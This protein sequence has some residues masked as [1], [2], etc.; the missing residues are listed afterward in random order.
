MLKFFRKRCRVAKMDRGLYPFELQHNLCFDSMFM[1]S[2]V[3]VFE[4]E[5]EAIDAMES[6]VSKKRVAKITVI[7]ECIL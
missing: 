5:V 4:T 1:W 3:D 6:Y 7:K 2:R